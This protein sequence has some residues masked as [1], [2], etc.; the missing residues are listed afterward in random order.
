MS[1]TASPASAPRT[2]SSVRRY[3]SYAER[4]R[5]SNTPTRPGAPTSP[6]RSVSQSQSQTHSRTSSGAQPQL[7]NVARRD[8]EQI[9]VARPSPSV[10]QSSESRDH[11]AMPSRSDSTRQTPTRPTDHS[12]YNSQDMTAIPPPVNTNG[13]MPNEGNHQIS[14]TGVRR[15]TTIDATTGHWELGKTIGAGSMGKVK[16]AKNK[17]TQEQ[18]RYRPYIRHYITPTDKMSHRSPSR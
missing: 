13:G 12:R 16:L 3:Q 15:R 10:P 18:V 6:R 7:V 4:D 11:S 1:T 9:N 14:S 2:P 8:F 5:S 17:E